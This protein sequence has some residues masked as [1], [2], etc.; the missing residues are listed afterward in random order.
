M[1]P[2]KI[3]PKIPPTTPA[4]AAGSPCFPFESAVPISA[5]PTIPPTKNP[6]KLNADKGFKHF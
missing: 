3:P 1:V 5:P 6:V 2:A 4:I